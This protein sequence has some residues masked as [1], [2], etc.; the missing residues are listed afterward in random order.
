MHDPRHPEDE[1]QDE[2]MTAAESAHCDVGFREIESIACIGESG[3]EL[4]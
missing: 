4:A 3:A 2:S 1:M